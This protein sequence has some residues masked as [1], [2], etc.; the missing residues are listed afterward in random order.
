VFFFGTL[1]HLRHPL[2]A[3]DQ[4]SSVCDGEIY[5]ES[6][7]CDDFSPYRGGFGRGY[8]DNQMVMEFYPGPEYGNNPT[9]WWAPTGQCLMHMTLAAGFDEAEA[10]KL[11]DNPQKVPHLRGFVRARKTQTPNAGAPTS[12][13]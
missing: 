12:S 3:L 2:L 11:A 10:W 1:Y 4:L 8:P 13:T 7:I 6:A 9:N 5:I